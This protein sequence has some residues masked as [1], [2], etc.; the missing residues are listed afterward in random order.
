[1]SENSKLS[2]YIIG[3]QSLLIRCADAL[4]QRHHEILGVITADPSVREWSESQGIAVI[5]PKSDL[6]AALSGRPFDY[7][8][9]IANF[10]IIS[11]EILSLPKLGAINFHDGPLP[12]YAG[13]NTPTWA[14]INGESEH[15][16]NWHVITSGID[17]G[18]ILESRSFPIDEN[19]IAFTLN[20]KCFDHGV[21]GFSDLVD[22]LADDTAAPQQQE[23][24]EYRYFAKDARPE[25]A[26][27]I[28]WS[29]SA[30]AISG[31]VRSLDYGPY[32]TP[33]GLPTTGNDY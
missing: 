26:S 19:E 16:I 22:A 24:G 10:R 31:L 21:T 32:W 33:M 30:D 14:L 5:D 18:D 13:L 7:L 4:L 29:S 6:V 8:F 3:G 20:A 17:K 25:A 28:D 12:D 11:D 23:L 1:M 15:A 27:L 2:C 9:S